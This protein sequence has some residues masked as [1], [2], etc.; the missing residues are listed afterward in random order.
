MSTNTATGSLASNVAATDAA[1]V[2]RKAAEKCQL[3]LSTLRDSHD[4]YK[5]C[6]T[7]TKDTAIRLLFDKIAGSR[8]DLI[9]QL[10]NSIRVD[11]GVEPYV[12]IFLDFNH[13][14][15]EILEFKPVPLLPLLI[16]HGS[17]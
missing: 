15:V 17:T 4:G 1:A 5:Q 13:F 16:E 3:V 8:A 14:Q 9:A 7:D 10:S 2:R 11:L 12:N 6:A